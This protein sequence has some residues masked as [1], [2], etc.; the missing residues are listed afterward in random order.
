MSNTPLATL[1]HHTDVNDIIIF[2]NLLY[3]ASYDSTIKVWDVSSD[4]IPAAPLHTLTGHSDNIQSL[5]IA[6]GKLYSGD[7]DGVI[8]VWLL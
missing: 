8:K 3:S 5:A 4:P 6:N 2:N 7:Y 1:T